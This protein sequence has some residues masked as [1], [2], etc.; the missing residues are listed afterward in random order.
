MRYGQDMNGFFESFFLTTL[1]F[2]VLSLCSAG[3]VMRQRNECRFENQLV[4]RRRVHVTK[5]R[6]R[7]HR[8]S[9]GAHGDEGT[10]ATVLPR[11]DLLEALA[12]RLVPRLLPLVDVARGLRKLAR[13]TRT[14][15]KRSVGSD[16]V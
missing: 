8:T 16:R 6:V 1:I 15:I 3:R 5:L 7:C 4:T 14:R 12:R 9:T 11:T 10:V 2:I 13:E